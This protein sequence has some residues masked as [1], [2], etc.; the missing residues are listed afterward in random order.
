MNLLLAQAIDPIRADRLR[1]SKLRRIEQV[2][3]IHPELT[4]YRSFKT[5]PETDRMRP[6][7]PQILSERISGRNI[8]RIE[9]I[10]DPSENVPAV[11]KRNGA[12]GLGQRNPRFEV[13]DRQR[14]ASERHG[15]GIERNDLAALITESAL[16]SD[17]YP[18]S[19]RFEVKPADGR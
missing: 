8:G 3:E 15:K 18:R 12:D 10:A 14:V 11:V 16:R 2:S 17:H 1:N 13:Y 9:D 5:Q 7:R 4:A 6:E 19:G